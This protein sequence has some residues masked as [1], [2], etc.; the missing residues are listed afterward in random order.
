ML[1]LGKKQNEEPWFMNKYKTCLAPFMFHLLSLLAKGTLTE[2][3]DGEY[4]LYGVPMIWL[5]TTNQF[6]L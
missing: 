6:V 1:Q 3:T 2:Y 4:W 5:L